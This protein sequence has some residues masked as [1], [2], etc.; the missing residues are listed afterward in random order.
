M[1]IE[2]HK[3]NWG[4][5]TAGNGL[6]FMGRA[7]TVTELSV[8]MCIRRSNVSHPMQVKEIAYHLSSLF[9]DSEAE[10]RGDAIISHSTARRNCATPNQANN[11]VTER[12]SVSTSIDSFP[13]GATFFQVIYSTALSD[14]SL[15][16]QGLEQRVY[17]VPPSAPLHYSNRHSDHSGRTKTKT[18]YFRRH[19]GSKTIRHA[20]SLPQS[21]VKSSQFVDLRTN[22]RPY[23]LHSQSDAGVGFWP[24]ERTVWLMGA[25]RR[26]I[27]PTGK[28]GP[29]YEQ[30]NEI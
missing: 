4:L 17:R 27:S 29:L 11:H 22:K 10:A 13:L 30:Q 6:S 19:P 2:L 5:Q 15:R 14:K 7:F 12:Q 21:S 3:R 24:D 1:R 20:V 28:N 8:V 25:D 23:H 26:R 18:D 9:A 16:K